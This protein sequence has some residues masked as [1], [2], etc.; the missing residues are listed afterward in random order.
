MKNV[1]SLFA[2][3]AILLFACSD[4]PDPGVSYFEVAVEEGYIDFGSD[5]W[6]FI[7]NGNGDVLDAKP[8]SNGNITRFYATIPEK[9][10][11]V[12]IATQTYAGDATHP[13]AIVFKSYLAVDTPA[14]WT[15]KQNENSTVNCG[16][17]KGTVNIAIND[18]GVGETFASCLSNPG[19]FSWPDYS[20]S[21]STALVYRPV[22]AKKLCDDFFLYVMG[23]DQQ[24][25]YKVLN[26]I[27]PGTYN[28]SLADLISFDQI[29]E[30]SFPKPTWSNLTVKAFEA[31]QSVYDPSTYINYDTKSVFE[32]DFATV[33]AGYLKTYT[34]YA[35][36]LDVFYL[37]S[38]RFQ[39][40]EAPGVPAAIAL[41]LSFNPVVTDKN[42][43][44]YQYT[45]NQ[46]VA[47]RESLFVYFS[48][49]L[50]E[51]IMEWNVFADGE[52]PFKHPAT[53]PDAFLEKYPGLLVEK[54]EHNF[55][56]FYTQYKSLNELVDEQYQAVPAPEAYKYV[57]KSVYH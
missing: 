39:Y 4:N 50:T 27:A 25:R 2:L 37:E 21:T 30:T 36:T 6:I 48:T 10:I 54:M 15:L 35:T 17:T 23:K 7:H 24:P 40:E 56:R 29:I 47:F 41:P 43:S 3:I 45:A 18:A 11:S 42:F 14:Q 26:D 57:S 44:T 9:K 51:Y 49:V 13:P 16:D 55:T 1:F 32:T 38:H 52:S 53:V 46:T 33:R 19:Y 12:T 5:A 34:R 22:E 20:L 8:L 28:F 31:T